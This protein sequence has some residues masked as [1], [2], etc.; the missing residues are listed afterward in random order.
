MKQLSPFAGWAALIL[1]VTALLTYLFLPEYT[2][3]TLT[4]SPMVD[5]GF[6]IS[7][8]SPPVIEPSSANRSASRARRSASRARYLARRSKMRMIGAIA[9]APMTTP[10]TIHDNQFI[11][12]YSPRCVG[13]TSNGAMLHPEG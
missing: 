6:L 2:L 13:M 10:S 11:R 1:G 5:S 4:F 12:S 9:A 8:A 7:C 3:L